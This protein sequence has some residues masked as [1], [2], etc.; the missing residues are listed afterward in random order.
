M[1]VSEYI[2]A[3]LYQEDCVI[4]PRFGGFV[5][6]YKDAKI[7]FK[8]LRMSP[9][10]KMIAFNQ[11]LQDNDGLLINY[12]ATQENISYESAEVEVSEY[13]SRLNSALKTG[14][15]VKFLDLGNFKQ[16]KLVV[17][18]TP[19]NS[20]NFHADAFGMESFDFPMLSSGPR[21]QIALKKKKL[22]PVQNK[23][24]RRVIAPLLI[25][26]PLIATLVYAPIYFQDKQEINQV[27]TA[28]IS[29]PVQLKK[30]QLKVD[31]IE[32]SKKQLEIVPVEENIN[33]EP[34]VNHSV[35]HKAIQGNVYVIAGSFSSVE[36][37]EK[38]VSD[39]AKKGYAA[40]VM[41]A[42]GGMNRVVLKT[43]N[44]RDEAYAALPNLKQSL[45]NDALW[46]L[47]N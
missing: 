6:K 34:V 39:F 2:K 45:G 29:I 8:T 21:K 14:K 27:E 1:K 40:S 16:E 15:K 3:L 28:G 9:P 7:D 41:S 19:E 30:H 20:I 35:A 44:S 24:R 23:K 46:V 33:E 38:A 36:N 32:L 47:A 17:V 10:S 18:F 43:Y 5:G 37:A 11:K 12:I 4:I 42:S 31:E 25:G 13:V 22:E 26:L